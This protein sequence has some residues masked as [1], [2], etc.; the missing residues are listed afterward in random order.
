MSN[1][2]TTKS[3]FK[4]LL[5]RTTSLNAE[6][7]HKFS[8]L[9]KTLKDKPEILE[10]SD[11]LP[12][13]LLQLRKDNEDILKKVYQLNRSLCNALGMEGSKSGGAN[14]ERLQYAI[15]SHDLQKRLKNIAHIANLL[16]DTVSIINNYQEEHKKHKKRLDSI[17]EKINESKKSASNSKRDTKQVSKQNHKDLK[18]QHRDEYGE[19]FSKDLRD[20]AQLQSRFQHSL[21]Q[22][23]Q[24]LHRYTGLAE[25]G[26][27]FNHIAGIKLADSQFYLS[28]TVNT[29]KTANKLKQ[30]AKSAR[31]MPFYTPKPKPY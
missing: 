20:S 25:F 6:F 4:T 18:S 1:T 12:K 13:K 16:S 31:T 30:Q 26:I 2:D 27:L 24:A 11:T 10:H 21:E 22:L 9:E 17:A 5:R 28:K 3:S 23:T 15:G 29:N 7:D 8:A 19:A 14:K